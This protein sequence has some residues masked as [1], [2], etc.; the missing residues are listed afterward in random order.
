[1]SDL[2]LFRIDGGAAVELQGSHV[3][4]EK[5]LQNLVE[6]N[7]EVMLGVHFLASEHSTG[8]RHRG[9][10][11]SL[12]IDENGSP[13][14]VEYKRTRNH[15][16]INQGLFY[17]Q[18]LLDHRADFQQVVRESAHHHFTYLIDWSA[19]RLICVATDFSRYDIEAVQLI[20]RAIDL[21]S[22]RDFSGQLLS[23]ELVH[24]NATDSTTTA[25]RR[26]TLAVPRGPAE[27]EESG[28][29]ISVAEDSD[30]GPPILEKLEQASPQLRELFEAL[31]EYC[32]FLGN[33]V[34]RKV[35][36]RYIAFYRRW[37]LVVL[38]IR[39]NE[40]KIVLHLKVNPD[41][42]ELKSGFT[43]DLRTTERQ[44]AVALEVTV[45][46]IEDLKPAYELIDRAYDNG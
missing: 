33:G 41:T 15:N 27:D 26:P 7:M 38:K 14:I 5:H 18:W 6:S 43:R 44:P 12:G 28:E 9:R 34:N 39:P 32:V 19:P 40:R 3:P 36:K 2:K 46:R 23:L 24:S 31:D 45:R 10:I 17:L 8:P 4:L 22:Y 35:L 20:D 29:D 25:A 1:M 37:N 21:I 42:V 13:V 11:D 16:V 30:T